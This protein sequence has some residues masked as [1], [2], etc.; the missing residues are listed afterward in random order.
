MH[1][2]GASTQDS[3]LGREK[4]DFKA[5]FLPRQTSW[6]P[7]QDASLLGI[8]GTPSG[9]GLVRG[10]TWILP[11]RLSR[12]SQPRT[13][14]YNPGHFAPFMSTLHFV[15]DGILP[16]R[17]GSFDRCPR[18]VAHKTSGSCA[19][20]IQHQWPSVSMAPSERP[21]FE[22]K[23]MRYRLTAGQIFSLRCLCCD[24]SGPL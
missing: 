14:P 15:F 8:W 1:Q 2:Y 22:E 4:I 18:F 24:R 13:S 9:E 12:F 6:N 21:R 16:P 19:L 5:Q 17:S 11:R 3:V 7:Y 20:A 23:C 10:Q